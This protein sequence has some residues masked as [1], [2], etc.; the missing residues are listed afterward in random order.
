ME[1][2]DAIAALSAL[3]QST[4]MQVFRLLVRHEPRGLPAGELARELD[5]PQ[6]TLST[7]LSILSHAGLLTSERNSRQII[8]RADLAG[9][10]ALMAYLLEDCCAGELC[11]PELLSA[12]RTCP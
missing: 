12:G 10:N 1:N 2:K 8:Y 11:L 9:M 3:A 5:V 7:H 6:N 4:R